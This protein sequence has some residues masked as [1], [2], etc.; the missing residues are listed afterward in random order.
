M[1]LVRFAMNFLKKRIKKIKADK[2]ALGHNF[3]DQA[4]TVLMRIL[5]GAGLDGLTGIP[6]VRKLSSVLIIRP[7]IECPRK[8]IEVFLK[9]HNLTWRQDS[10]NLKDI[11][12]RN[13][14]RLK[15]LSLIEKEY[16]PAIKKILSSFQ[17]LQDR[18]LI[19]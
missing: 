19:F 6:P 14:I 18:T 4:E 12:F 1:H 17:K 7:L 15:L 11:Y 9:S 10:S 16:S 5:R 2:L 8:E 13:K 3:D